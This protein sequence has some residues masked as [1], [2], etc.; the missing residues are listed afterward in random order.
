MKTQY[1]TTFTTREDVIETLK[2]TD[3]FGGRDYLLKNNILLVSFPGHIYVYQFGSD[4]LMT[5]QDVATLDPDE[6]A[7]H[8][9]CGELYMWST[10]T[11]DTFVDE[12]CADM[13][14]FNIFGC[15]AFTSHKT[16][17]CQ[18]L[19]QP[20]TIS[21]DSDVG[22]LTNAKLYFPNT[23]LDKLECVGESYHRNHLYNVKALRDGLVKNK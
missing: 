3:G 9:M 5:L 2:I 11:V 1:H 19:R 8:H 18:W 17:W 10:D 20:Y 14:G 4:T 22:T 21:F 12:H 7:E 23:P 13:P 6:L 15:S 16:S